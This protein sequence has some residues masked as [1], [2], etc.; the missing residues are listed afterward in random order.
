V[1][2][3]AGGR[4][5][6]PITHSILHHP[7]ICI[8]SMPKRMAFNM[9][10][11]SYQLRVGAIPMYKRHCEAKIAGAALETHVLPNSQNSCIRV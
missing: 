9:F 7:N 4:L 1:T 8:S 6:G 2:R 5:W 11:R 3:V 10:T